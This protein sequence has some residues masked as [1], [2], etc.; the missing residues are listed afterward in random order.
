MQITRFDHLTE[1]QFLGCTSAF[2]DSLFG[3]LNAGAIYLRKLEGQSKGSAFAYEMSLDHHRY[4]ALLVLER[5]TT[6]VAAFGPHL[7]LDRRGRMVEEAAARV[8]TA[9]EILHNAN[10]L[11]DAAEFYSAEMVQACLLGFQ[12]LQTTFAEE[13]TAAEQ[14]TKLGPMLPEEF[15]KARRVFLEDLAS[16]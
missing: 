8:Q 9:E 1:P 14:S 4:G 7:E 6:L 3:Q 16:R 11:I 13:R 5:W 12:S 15:N 2:V 10:A